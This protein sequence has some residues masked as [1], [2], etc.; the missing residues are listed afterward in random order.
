MQHGREP[1]GYA[2]PSCDYHGCV[3]PAHLEDQP[4][5]QHLATQYAAIF[6]SAA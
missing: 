2:L 3:A 6:G 4:M 1:V 5:R